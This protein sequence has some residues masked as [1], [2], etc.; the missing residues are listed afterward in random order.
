MSWPMSLR[1]RLTCGLL[2]LLAVCCAVVG[3]TAAIALRSVLTDR[4]DEQLTQATDRLP[5]SLGTSQRNR[6]DGDSG[7]TR[8]QM[9]GTLGVLLQDGSLLDSAV[10]DA[11]ESTTAQMNAEDVATL[12]ALPHDGQ[13]H[14]VRLSNVGDYRVVSVK[15]D[16]GKTLITGLP[17]APVDDAVWQLEMVC[18][19]VFGA[20]LLA[21][22]LV[23]VLWIR[24]SLKPLQEVAA[25]ATEITRLPLTSGE[26]RLPPLASETDRRTEVGV[27]G[28]ALNRMV[29]HVERALAQRQ[30]SAEQLRRFAADAS[31][32]LRT[33]LAT[34]RGY[35]ELSLGETEP[36]PVSVLRALQRIEVT[37]ARMGELVDEMLLLAR[38][39]AGRPLASEDVDLSLVALEAIEDARAAGP[40]HDWQLDLPDVPVMIIGDPQRLRQVID[41]LLANARLH[42][43]A[44]TRVTLALRRDRQTDAQLT[45]GQGG[46]DGWVRFSVGD[47]GPGVPRELQAGLFD[48]F[49]RGDGLDESKQAGA[50]LGLSI[51]TA[52]TEAHGGLV[53]M[54]SR[55]GAT[56]FA[57]L[58]PERGVPE[59]ANTDRL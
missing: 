23:G 32:E 34:I 54:T 15:G 22:G 5:A 38:L 29:G 30:R 52:V 18:A 55:P 21:T 16:A 56:E 26:V 47:N 58:L 59:I 14:S 1:A 43:P 57:V 19:A 31:H 41:N 33:P 27:V 42:T 35:A 39:D 2:V 50:G 4:L 10:V 28:A 37:S 17:L 36:V 7:D 24:W 49:V 8:G 44:G 3:L 11:G 51:V 40:D 20:A 46:D 48:R 45:G 13:A 53:Q 25:V 9:Q 12:A 6:L